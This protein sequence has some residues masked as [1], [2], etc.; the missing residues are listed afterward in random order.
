[1]EYT[2]CHDDK[3]DYSPN[4][5]YISTHGADADLHVCELDDGHENEHVCCCGTAWT[6]LG[7]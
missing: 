6:N 1:M 3:P 7:E 4:A 5:C 2:D